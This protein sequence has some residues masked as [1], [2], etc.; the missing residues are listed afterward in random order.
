RAEG[1]IRHCL[2]L[3]DLDHITTKRLLASINSILLRVQQPL[4]MCRLF[5]LLLFCS[6]LIANDCAIIRHG[7]VKRGCCAP[8]GECGGGFYPAGGF[9]RGY[10]PGGGGGYGRMGMFG[11][12]RFGGFQYGRGPF[13]GYG[14]M[15]PMGPGPVG[16]IGPP[17]MA[18][19]A[20]SSGSQSEIS[21][22]TSFKASS[23]SGSSFN[24]VGGR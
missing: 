20:A 7:R 21:I 3:I 22:S 1:H 13:G 8:C 4:E 24:A 17:P 14:P 23:G 11:G 9:G 18:A 10:F 6:I 16:P 15:G 19:A 12:R 5:F 2:C